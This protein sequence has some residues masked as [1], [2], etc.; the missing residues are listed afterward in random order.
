MSV[1]S[2]AAKYPAVALDQGHHSGGPG[3]ANIRS[4]LKVS[5]ESNDMEKETETAYY[6]SAGGRSEREK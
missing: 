1:V 3:E 6:L 2:A 5:N 4:L